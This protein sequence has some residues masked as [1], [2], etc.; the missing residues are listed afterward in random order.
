MRVDKKDLGKDKPKK[1]DYSA[2]TKEGNPFPEWITH[3]NEDELPEWAKEIHNGAE[4][5]RSAKERGTEYVT[6]TEAEA[7]RLASRPERETVWKTSKGNTQRDNPH[8]KALAVERARVAQERYE[9]SFRYLI[10]LAIRLT[11]MWVKV[12]AILLTLLIITLLRV[13]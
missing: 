3:P 13:T 6:I 8:L 11:P 12:S 4:R 1:P 10:P 7:E 5:L 2:L 9:N